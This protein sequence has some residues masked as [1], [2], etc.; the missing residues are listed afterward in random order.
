MPVQQS[1]CHQAYRQSHH[2][3]PALPQTRQRQE[4]GSSPTRYAAQ[5]VLN[6]LGITH[7]RNHRLAHPD[8]RPARPFHKGQGSNLRPLRAYTI[9]LLNPEE[10]PFRACHHGDAPE[11]RDALRLQYIDARPE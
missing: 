9:V 1:G 5:A 3:K 8:N 4:H 10:R 11:Y 7:I 2:Y 6:L